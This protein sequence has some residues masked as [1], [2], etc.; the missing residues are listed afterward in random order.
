M[1]VNSKMKR[2]VKLEKREAKLES[3]SISRKKG[4]W[5]LGPWGTR[6][7]GGRIVIFR[8]GQA[9]QH[10]AV[11][12]RLSVRSIFQRLAVSHYSRDWSTVYPALVM[13]RGSLTESASCCEA[14]ALGS[15]EGKVG[16]ERD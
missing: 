10:V 6:S 4:W 9:T 14:V 12:V 5:A 15:D 16:G 8:R 13:L 1:L 3:N 7:Q 2:K 11:S